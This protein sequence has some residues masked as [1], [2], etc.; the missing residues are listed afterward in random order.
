M[1]DRD[2]LRETLGKEGMRMVYKT[3]MHGNNV[4]QFQENTKLIIII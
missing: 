2:F 3:T 4:A 1:E